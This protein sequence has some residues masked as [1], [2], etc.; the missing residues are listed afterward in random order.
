M[1]QNSAGSTSLGYLREPEKWCQVVQILDSHQ[2]AA[3]DYYLCH[4]KPRMSPGDNSRE[5]LTELFAIANHQRRGVNWE[6]L[7]VKN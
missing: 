4:L 1:G 6:N 3:R 7:K 2:L 5:R